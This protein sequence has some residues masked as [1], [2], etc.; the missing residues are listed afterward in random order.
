MLFGG[1]ELRAKRGESK[2][3]GTNETCNSQEPIRTSAPHPG[4][5]PRPPAAVP[6]GR[7][8]HLGGKSRAR[9]ALRGLLILSVGRRTRTHYYP[10]RTLRPRRTSGSIVGS[11]CV[12]GRLPEEGERR[13]PPGSPGEKGSAC[14]AGPGAWVAGAPDAPHQRPSSLGAPRAAFRAP[15]ASSA[16]TASAPARSASGA[17][18]RVRR[19]QGAPPA[20][21][22]RAR[23]RTRPVRVSEPRAA[24]ARVP[25]L[26]VEAGGG[27]GV[28]VGLCPRPGYRRPPLTVGAEGTGRAARAAGF[29]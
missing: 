27:S 15:G 11:G 17:T 3:K 26:A 12:P 22:A 23:A 2:K 10:S 13:A 8:Q 25:A 6:A 9:A 18:T 19:R 28:G 29:M 20:A 14:S 7:G 16:D 21:P 5:Q 1:E 24:A 4:E